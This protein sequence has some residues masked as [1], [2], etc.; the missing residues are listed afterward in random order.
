MLRTKQWMAKKI[1]FLLISGF[2]LP[3]A[4]FS[5]SLI[6]KSAKGQ[7][8]NPAVVRNPDSSSQE[9]PRTG[10]IKGRILD[11]ETLK[12]LAGVSITVKE[13]DIEVRSDKEG[14]YTVPDI[15][16]GYYVL[17]IQLDGYY[18]DT[19]T[20]VIVR[21]QRTTFLNLQMLAV[22]M[23][24]EEVNVTADYFPP[25]PNKPGS[26]MQINAEEMR[27]D[28]ASAGD[29]SRALYTVPGII[30]SEEEANDLIVR[31]GHPSENGF[32][33]DNIFIPNI[34]H[35]P[36]HGASGGNISMLNIDFIERLQVYTGGFD[37]SYGNRLSSII[38]IG[39]REGN[40][41]KINSQ[42]NFSVIRYGA[43][44]EGPLPRKKGAWI[45]SANHSFLDLIR[46]IIS[47]DDDRSSFYEIQGKMNYDLNVN[48]QV[49]LLMVGGHSQTVY[50]VGSERFNQF[51]S[52]FNWRHLWGGKGYSDTSIS[53]SSLEAAEDSVAGP[54]N[55]LFLN[56][57]YSNSWI[58][59][60]NVNQLQLSLS[61]QL[62]FGVEAQNVKSRTF[63]YYEEDSKKFNGTFGAAFFTYIVYPFNNFSLSSGFRLD[64]F[65][66]S[67]RF[68]LSPRLSFSWVLTNR[69]SVNGAFGMF[70]QQMPLFLLKQHAEN[71]KLRDSQ[72]RHLVLGFKYLLNQNTQ[73]TLEAY[74]KKYNN[75]P[76]SPVYPYFFVIDD[77]QGDDDTY[78]NWGSLVDEGKAYARGV[79]L[80]VQKKL[81]KSL[82]GLINFTYYRA[83]YRDLMGVW[84]N[85]M[86][87]NHFIICIFGG[88]KPNKYWEFN[89][90]WIW[91][92]N[93]AF[94][95]VNEEKSKQYGWPWVDYEDIMSGHLSN[96]Q[97]LSLRVDRRF[98]FK[99]SNLV[100]FAGALNILDH[101][102]EL[103]RYWFSSINAYES[104]Y[105]WGIIPY[106]GFE[107]EF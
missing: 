56:Y 82:Y 9:T 11:Y 91:S 78:G 62:K 37:A 67:E 101:K 36:Q 72:A 71:I 88:Y 34:N 15:P 107:L 102:N 42:V 31:G 27:R 52:G 100:L 48:N 28:A 46:K 2:L 39:Y 49:S 33:I 30:K 69:L 19:R 95:P 6:Q 97:N 104:E 83:R 50:D 87:D 68:H 14:I 18:S 21:S 79:E 85:R 3:G 74:D 4:T 25:T 26:Q 24:R 90:R 105:M 16:V 94:T 23:I 70:Y 40:R 75:F 47:D 35:F 61:H 38:D 51:T 89:I 96:Y 77:V 65:P 63:D 81:A 10:V 54:E 106:I 84:R 92:G 13:T 5:R 7:E 73:L 58:T 55:E 57:D 98:Y 17:S 80:T 8:K 60:R 103:D 32:Y 64:Y 93:K 59:F 76:M 45:V 29:V 12:P 99:K 41:D 44:I 43:Q 22:R 1:V 66:F 86:F 20:D 53:Y